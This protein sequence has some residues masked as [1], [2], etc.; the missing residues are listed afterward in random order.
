MTSNRPS[1]DDLQWGRKTRRTVEGA[2]ERR[3]NRRNML[4]VVAVALAAVGMAVGVPGLLGLDGVDAQSASAALVVERP[5]APVA[6]TR[7]HDPYPLV[8]AD[9]EGV[10][11][12]SAADFADGVAHDFTFMVDGR[13]VEFFVIQDKDGVIRAA[14]DAC[15]VCYRAKLG[16]RQDGRVMVCNNCG[17]HFPIEQINMVRGG[18]NP[19]P[20]ERR[21]DG[22]DLVIGAADLAAGL[23][24]F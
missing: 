9:E 20:L 24:Y 1:P 10:A 19:A 18:C 11:R 13:P 15:D 8:V 3:R 7:N 23:S 17:N 16:Y 6:A 12:F 2:V 14:Y 21:L 4:G 5:L 22:D